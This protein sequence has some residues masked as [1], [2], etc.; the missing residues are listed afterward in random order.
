MP[1]SRTRRYFTKP[2]SLA[3][4]MASAD[5]KA[6]GGLPSDAGT[7]SSEAAVDAKDS[8][9]KSSQEPIKSKKPNVKPGI[10][11]AAQDSLPKLPIPELSST[12]KKFLDALAP[13]QSEREHDE[14]RAAAREFEVGEG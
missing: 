1:F 12:L 9:P 8:I 5:S 6:D 13:L 11:Y 7:R 10:T 14:S 4:S 3:E 2:T